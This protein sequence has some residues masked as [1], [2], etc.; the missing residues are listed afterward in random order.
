MVMLPRGPYWATNDVGMGEMARLRYGQMRW[1]IEVYHRTLKQGCGVERAQMRA[2]RAQ[3]NHIGLAIRCLCV[4]SG[5]G[6]APV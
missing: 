5:T 6:Y 2:A 1:S 4:S 3:R